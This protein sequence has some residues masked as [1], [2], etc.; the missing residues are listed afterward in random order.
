MRE[1]GV[2]VVDPFSQVHLEAKRV[3]PVVAPDDVFF[4]GAHDAFGVWIAFW[5]WPG[6]EDLFD[7]Q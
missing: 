7:T 2:V 4:D 3:F 6:C 1:V 5:V